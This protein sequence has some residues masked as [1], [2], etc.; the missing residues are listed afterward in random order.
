MT[1]QD[2]ICEE[3]YVIGLMGAI[4]F[5]SFS[6]GSLAFTDMVDKKGRKMIVLAAT[7]V[8]PLGILAMMLFADN[9]YHIYT[10]MFLV[11]L[12]Y[13]PR[14]SVAYLYGSEFLDKESRFIFGMFNFVISGILCGLSALWFYVTKDQNLYFLI[15]IILILIA[16]FWVAIAVPESP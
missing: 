9:I 4:S 7:M 5:I 10:I 15:L 8:T 16:M 2:L 11:G 6:V 14:G 13:N 12:T 3:P 1:Q